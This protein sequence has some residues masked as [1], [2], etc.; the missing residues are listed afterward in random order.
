M[1]QFRVINYLII[2]VTLQLFVITRRMINCSTPVGRA[3][4]NAEQKR[5]IQITYP[6]YFH[7]AQKYASRPHSFYYIQIH[8]IDL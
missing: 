4:L 7:V 3:M 8:Y 5:I 1:Q 6:Y 2:R